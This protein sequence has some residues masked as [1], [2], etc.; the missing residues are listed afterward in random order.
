[1]SPVDIILVERP[2][3]RSSTLPCLI[4]TRALSIP[5]ER[6]QYPPLIPPRTS[7]INL[8]V[9][10]RWH[11]WKPRSTHLATDPCATQRE[12]EHD[13]YGHHPPSICPL[14]PSPMATRHIIP[15]SSP[16]FLTRARLR[17][18]HHSTSTDRITMLPSTMS[19]PTASTSIAPAIS[20][21][22]Y[23]K[24]RVEGY[25]RYLHTSH[26]VS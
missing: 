9:I 4:L 10:Y 26:A 5:T 23:A 13:I 20:P 11:S 25:P 14:L 6:T 8:H 18:R 1:M 22:R 12:A 19:T 2:T 15:C 17:L 24:K 21:A 16:R 3:P 7:S